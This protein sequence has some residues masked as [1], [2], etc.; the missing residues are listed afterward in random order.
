MNGQELEVKFHVSNLAAI[1]ERL[2]ALNALQ[3]H[4]RLHELNLRFDTPDLQLRRNQKVLRLRRDDSAHI[5]YKGPGHTQAGVRVRQEIEITLDDFDAARALLEALGYQVSVMYEKYRTAYHL[6]GALITLD[7]MPYGEFVEIEGPD[8]LC[9]RT[10]SQRLGLDWEKRIPE[11]YLVLF[12]RLKT[13]LNLPF[14]DLTF[15]NF[16]GISS[17]MRILHIHPADN[18]V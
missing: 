6:E 4:P 2:R 16:A 3:V 11:S 15:A 13:A 8:P 18:Q 12:E 10:V 5:T 9:I 1:E 14:R 7:E 17:P